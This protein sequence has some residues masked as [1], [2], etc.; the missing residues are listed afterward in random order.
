MGFFNSRQVTKDEFWL[1]IITLMLSGVVS[2]FVSSHLH[3]TWSEDRWKL[4]VFQR[5]V[6]NSHFAATGS[7]GP[8]GEPYVALNEVSVVFANDT[9]VISALEKLHREKDGESLIDLCKAMAEAL[10]LPLNEEFIAGPL[11]PVSPN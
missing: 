3:D 10:K 1:S 7:E 2:A 5:I 6:G 11:T 8:S 4:E 9:E